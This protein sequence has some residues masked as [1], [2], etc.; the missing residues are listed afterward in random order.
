MNEL[1]IM[2]CFATACLKN[3]IKLKSNSC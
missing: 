1:A 3:E 2:I